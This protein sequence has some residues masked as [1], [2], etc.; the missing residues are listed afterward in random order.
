[1]NRQRL[2]LKRSAAYVL[3]IILLFLVLAPVGMLVQSVLGIRPV[4]GFEVWQVTLLNFSVPVWLYFILC[5]QS[6]SGATVGKRLLRVRVS[7][8]AN[9]SKSPGLGQAAL[10]T[11]IKLLPWE[12]VHISAFALGGDF[13]DF[14]MLQAAGISIGNILTIAYLALAIAT[15]GQRSMHDFAAKTFVGETIHSGPRNEIVL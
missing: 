1:M 10:R 6:A 13:S 14:S 2:I 3:D 15:S 7:D 12:V 5:D 9:P 11:L 8:L 4:S